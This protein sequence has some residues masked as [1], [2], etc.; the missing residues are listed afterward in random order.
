MMDKKCVRTSFLLGE[1]SH[2]QLTNK[3]ICIFGLGAVGTFCLEFL[4]RCGISCFTLVDFDTVTESNFN[5]L[6]TAVESN[7]GKQKAE[8]ARQRVLSINPAAEV[9][10]ESSF[11]GTENTESFIKSHKFDLIIDAID[12]L[13]PKINL[14]EVVI[15]HQLPAVSSMGAAGRRRSSM[16]K[17][18]DLMSTTNCPLA[19]FVRKGLHRRG[20]KGS[21]PAVYSTEVPHPA[22]SR[23][24]ENEGESSGYYERGRT[25]SLQ[26]S[27]VYIPA[28][29]AA[30][31]TETAINIL[32]KNME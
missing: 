24:E 2:S 13:N 4:A 12:S 3:H 15:R 10:A 29:F 6:L 7:M 26:P 25:R 27:I 18:G 23:E 9:L 16:V 20:V 30:F 17:V 22:R 5:R 14:L 32:L 21:L 31:L 19:K 1:D 8:A 11:M 28:V